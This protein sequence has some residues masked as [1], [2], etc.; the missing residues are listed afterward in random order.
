MC[1]VG[2]VV[3][4]GVG[5]GAAVA[6]AIHFHVA[7]SRSVAAT[8]GDSAVNVGGALRDVADADGTHHGQVVGILG[9]ELLGL[10]KGVVDGAVAGFVVACVSPD[11][12]RRG[13]IEKLFGNGWV[14][15]EGDFKRA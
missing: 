2:V 6:N 3:F 9:N 8:V 15:R 10:G 11:V 12:I 14:E 13:R 5:I 7:E 4:G 1:A